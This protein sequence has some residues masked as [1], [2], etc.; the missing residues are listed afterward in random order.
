MDTPFFSLWN[1][2]GFRFCPSSR[3][4]PTLSLPPPSVSKGSLTSRLENWLENLWPS[5]KVSED[6]NIE[7]L[8][9]QQSREGWKLTSCFSP[10]GSQLRLVESIYIYI[11]ICEIFRA[12]INKSKSNV[13]IRISE[14]EESREYRVYIYI[15]FIQK[16]VV[17]IANRVCIFSTFTLVMIKSVTEN[18]PAN[19]W[20]VKYLPYKQ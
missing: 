13:I 11:Y 19:P 5:K 16:L 10:P 1:E 9:P 3:S 4:P 15:L 18:R 17:P 20:V 7:A 2:Y 8:G 12:A 14:E 6:T